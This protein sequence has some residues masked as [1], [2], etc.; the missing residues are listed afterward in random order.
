MSS[1]IIKPEQQS[2]TTVICT[3]SKSHLKRPDSYLVHDP[4]GKAAWKLV[5]PTILL[6]V[7]ASLYTVCEYVLVGKLSSTTA[8]DE[9]IILAT[10]S[11]VSP[12][13][14]GLIH[15]LS[16]FLN[17][18]SSVYLSQLI[19]NHSYREGDRVFGNVLTLQFFQFILIVSILYY[20]LPSLLKL[21]LDHENSVLFQLGLSY[22]RTLLGTSLFSFVAVALSGFIRNQGFSLVCC[23]ISFLSTVVNVF[24]DYVFIRCWG[25]G[26]NGAALASSCSYLLSF[27]LSY[28][29][30]QTKQ[31]SIHFHFSNLLLHRPT[32]KAIFRMGVPGLISTLSQS[33][34]SIVSNRLLLRFS[35]SSQESSMLLSCWSLLQKWHFVGVVPLLAFSQGILPL[36]ASAFGSHS[37]SRFCQCVTLLLKVMCFLSLV[38]Q[39]GLITCS[40][41]LATSLSSDGVFQSFFS[42]G[43]KWFL[44]T[45]LLDAFSFTVFTILQS[46]GKGLAA[47]IILVSKEGVLILLQTILSYL[48]QSYWGFIYASPIASGVTF[49]IS[50]CMYY[51]HCRWI[52]SYV[53]LYNKDQ[54]LELRGVFIDC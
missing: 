10:I 15:C 44:S 46:M 31:S 43:L 26:L 36:L 53:D 17:V 1:T 51:H 24:F 48:F 8:L 22:S 21:F 54:Q 25:W 4:V 49:L 35:H 50:I 41:L 2:D 6:M 39:L 20:S 32:C 18:G 40:S 52:H 30:L 12:I 13:E 7:F 19:G 34:T 29:F 23:I 3:S 11:L 38:A 28:C 45:L 14:Q 37:R 33:F 5:Y 42:K 47:S 27:F 16:S 9:S